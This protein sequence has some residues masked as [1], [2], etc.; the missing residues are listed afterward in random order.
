MAKGSPELGDK[1]EVGRTDLTVREFVSGQKLFRRYT[2]V[3]ILGRGGMGIVWLARDSDL[4]R[5]VALKFLPEMIIHDPA[6]LADLKR[7]TRRSLEL[8]HPHIVRIH[9]FVQDSNSACISMEYVDGDTLSGLRAAKPSK[10]FEAPELET[11]LKQWCD[12]MDYAHRHARVVHCD[13]KPANLMVNSKGLLKITDFGIARSL[14]D[15]ATK[16]TATRTHTGTLVYMSPQQLD[17]ERP[18]HLDDIYSMGASLYELLTSKP[19]FYHGQIDRQIRERIPLP[20]ALRRQELEVDSAFVIPQVWEETVAA[21]LAKNPLQRP[22]SAGE[23][24]ER[25]VLSGTP[26]HPSDLRI[27]E[28]SVVKK[29]KKARFSNWSRSIKNALLSTL[30]IFRRGYASV[31]AAA[32]RQRNILQN[33]LASIRAAAARNRRNPIVYGAVSVAAL[34]IVLL[35]LYFGSPRSREW[36]LSPFLPSEPSKNSPFPQMTPSETA[37]PF[38]PYASNDVDQLVKHVDALHKSGQTK[39]TLSRLEQLTERDPTNAAALAEQALLYEKTQQFDLATKIWW[40]VYATGS[41]WGA[42]YDFAATKLKTRFQAT[43]VETPSVPSARNNRTWQAQMDE[44]VRQFVES[45]GSSDVIREASFYAPNAQIFEEGPK[46]LDSIRHDIET[47]KTTWPVRSS[48]ISGAV[49]VTEKVPNEEYGASFEQDYLC[50]N[51]TRSEWVKGTVAVDLRI[52]VIDGLPK[53]SSIKQ[54]MLS[55]E[56]GTGKPP[57]QRSATSA[58]AT[59]PSPP[60]NRPW[61]ERIDEFVKQYESSSELGVDSQLALYAP[62]VRY[63]GDQQRDHTYIRTDVERYRERWPVRRGSIEGDIDLQEKIPDEEYAASYK[64]NFYAESTARAQWSKGQ[65]A[66]DLDISIVDGVPKTSGIKEKILSQQKGNLKAQALDPKQKEERQRRAAE[67]QRQAEISAAEEKIKQNP[68]GQNTSPTP[69]PSASR[70]VYVVNAPESKLLNL[71]SDHSA[72]SPVI[73]KLKQG[74]KVFLEDGNVRNDDPPHPTTW[75][76]VTTMNGATGWIAFDYLAPE[77]ESNQETIAGAPTNEKGPQP[78]KKVSVEKYNLSVVLPTDVFPNAEDLSSSRLG[79]DSLKSDS[80]GASVRFYMERKSVSDA[81]RDCTVEHPKTGPERA[82]GYKALRN[83]WFV[84][85]GEFRSGSSN[86]IGFYIK[87]VKAGGSVLFMQLEYK[88]N[89]CPFTKDTFTAMFR[90]FTGK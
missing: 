13:L 8:T 90:S 28:K 47:Y 26:Q 81:Y 70:P 80:T 32:I 49:R 39:E 23:L 3:R 71:R 73:E 48:S 57:A 55:R 66:I 21:C 31:N 9:D 64:L 77:D 89:D 29:P 75:Q 20:M 68:E 42:L 30:N 58:S 18:S 59:S 24:A 38:I 84:V 27:A 85:S 37:P 12:A 5:D 79:E 4:E 35:S 87:G 60:N 33:A 65:F 7:E 11:W 46:T 63:F 69:A 2:L 50:E 22:Q 41:R 14:S 16:L 34:I 44:F 15:S 53:I 56:K 82:I 76:K 10:V 19:P 54:N 86:G 72:K 40:K 43:A 78:L 67:D 52:T 6:V 1:S 83:D 74:D 17:G 36:L 51:P 45:N 88:E 62:N 61:R 25:L